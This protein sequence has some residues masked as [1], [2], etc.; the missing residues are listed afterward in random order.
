MNCQLNNKPNE[1]KDQPYI[2]K[3]VIFQ[4]KYN[5][6][7][8]VYSYLSSSASPFRYTIPKLKYIQLPPTNK[9]I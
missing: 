4:L 7:L 1:D 5:N 9:Q 6:I 2:G 3:K 8:S